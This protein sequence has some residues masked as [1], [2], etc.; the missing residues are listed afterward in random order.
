MVSRHAQYARSFR[1]LRPAGDENLIS[2]GNVA[3]RADLA[4]QSHRLSSGGLIDRSRVYRFHFDGRLYSGHP[5]DTL[6]SALLANGVRLVGRSFKYHRPRGIMTIGSDEPNALVSLRSGARHE[7]NLRATTVEL[8][9]GLAAESQNRWPSLSFDLRAIAQLAGPLMGAGFYYKTFMWPQAFWEKVYEPLIRRAAGLGRPPEAHD[10]DSYEK[11]T[12][13]CDVLVVGSGLAGLGAALAAARAGARVVLC[14]EDFRL[15]GRLLLERNIFT[16]TS[17]TAWIESV[18]SEL[19][20]NPDV[21]VLHRTTVFG[22]YDHGVYGAVE[23]VS[24]HLAEPLPH[25]P[26]QRLWRIIAKSAVFATGST[27]RPLLFGNN[28]RPG[29]MLAGAVRGYVNGFAAV[30]GRR[31]VVVTNNDDGYRTARDLA[32]ANVDVRAIVDVR[33]KRSGSSDHLCAAVDAPVIHGMVTDVAGASEVRGVEILTGEGRERIDCDVV[34]AAGGWSPNVHLACHVGGRPSWDDP[35]AAFLAGD[36]PKG[37]RMAGSAAGIFSSR[38]ALLSGIQAGV[39]TAALAGFQGKAFAAPAMGHETYEVR[40]NWHIPV[41]RGKVFVDF[42]NDVSSADIEL[43]QR[44]GFASI[45]HVKRY[46]TLGMGTD[47]GKTAGVNAIAVLSGLQRKPMG[48]VG[49]TTFRP[50]YTPVSMG[51]LAGHH[52][53]KALKPTRLSPTHAWSSKQGAVFIEAGMWLRAQYFPVNGE[54]WFASAC[55]EAS[56]VRRAVG[57]ADVS[58]LGKIDVQ[59]PDAAEFL[60]RVY[61]NTISNLAVGKARYG[62][63]LREDG[64]VFDDGTVARLRESHFLVTTTTV[65][66]PAA[67]AHLEHCAQWIW[68]DL[69]VT[70]T[71]VTEQWAQIALAGPLARD[72]LRAVV[73]PR[74]DV[75]NE[76]FPFM[77]CAALMLRDGIAGRLFRLSFSGELGFEIAVPARWGEALAH[78]LMQAGRPHGMV[79]YGLEAMSILRV[80]K[81][82]AAGGELNGQTTA[83]DLGLGRMVSKKKDF[84]GRAMAERRALTDPDRPALAGFQALDGKRLNAGAH[85]LSISS[86]LAP[87]ADEGHLTSTAFSPTLGCWI[88]LGLIRRGNDRIGE[89]VRVIDPIRNHEAVVEITRPSFLDPQGERLRG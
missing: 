64:F 42:Q 62:I 76:A 41:A 75:S 15:G 12:I 73:D 88:A 60:D 85:L 45:E 21:N 4:R 8:Y 52:R 65:N 26:R 87:D 16:E 19:R 6:A 70:I 79:P 54:D 13:H 30:P 80:E 29:V 67:L 46:T 63:M 9:D 48:A 78:R 59:G 36:L 61:A 18:E 82:H 55:R 7:P 57:M 53:G 35:L 40:P 72:V 31:V 11:V 27:E 39:D 10:P 51:V 69:D 86:Q 56:A 81:G 74:M 47:Q 22:M 58:T 28:D 17:P 25:Q 71:S 33:P 89:R 1:C 3:V 84:I 37:V 49:T 50:P 2:F 38:E 43:A 83:K 44:E 34:A 20:A 68:S 14:D 24:D 23:R 5:G 32:N 66:A 77:A